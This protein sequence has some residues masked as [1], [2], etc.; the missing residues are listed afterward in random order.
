MKSARFRG[1]VDFDDVPGDVAA[2]QYIPYFFRDREVIERLMRELG[3]EDRA[4]VL[5]H[6]TRPA[7]IGSIFRPTSRSA[8]SRWTSMS[9]TLTGTSCSEPIITARAISFHSSTA[10][11]W[12]RSDA[13]AGPLPKPSRALKRVLDEIGVELPQV[14]LLSP[15][16]S[17][18]IGH[19]GHLNVHLMMRKM[20]WWKGSPVL[21]AYKERIANKTLPVARSRSCARP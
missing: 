13:C 11:T 19:N 8:P 17:A 18:L 9:G 20:G 3:L 12:R 16:W 14:R 1:R 7:N 6:S 10:A 2:E 21:L 15:D 5:R 4:G